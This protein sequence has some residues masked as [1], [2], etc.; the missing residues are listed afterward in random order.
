MDGSGTVAKTL[1]HLDFCALPIPLLCSDKPTPPSQWLLRTVF[2]NI[3][4]IGNLLFCLVCA[5]AK[6]LCSI[7]D[8][9]SS[10]RS[11]SL[12]SL[13]SVSF[14]CLLLCPS[15]FVVT[16]R[17]PS[18]MFCYQLQFWNHTCSNKIPYLF[19]AYL[20]WLTSGL[21]PSWHGWWPWSWWQVF[22]GGSEG[23]LVLA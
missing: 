21:P 10:R 6:T 14:F 19:E 20:L 3:G 11:V 2:G 13:V 7:S 5:D 15:S 12:L 17:D 16:S 22:F 8:P 23:K 1:C 4:V 18:S 9:C